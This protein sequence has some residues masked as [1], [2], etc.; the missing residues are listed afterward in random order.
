MPWVE[1]PKIKPLDDVDIT[2][3][4]W[5]KCEFSRNFGDFVLSRA[6][7]YFIVTIEIPCITSIHICYYINY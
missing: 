7:T 2:S 5:P 3:V 1:F 4:I 6:Y